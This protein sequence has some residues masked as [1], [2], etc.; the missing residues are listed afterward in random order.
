MGNAEGGFNA[1]LTARRFIASRA[2]HDRKSYRPQLPI[3]NNDHYRYIQQMSKQ[4]A[5]KLRKAIRESGLSAARLGKATGV[6]Q[7]V[8]SEFL[9]GKDIRLTTAQKL[10]DYFGLKL[11][12][13]SRRK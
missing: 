13:A 9:R 4:M 2:R 10:A 5:E 3:V 8:I 11:T 6:T 12:E 7:P 1:S